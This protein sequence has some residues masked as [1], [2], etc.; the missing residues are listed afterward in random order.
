MQRTCIAGGTGRESQTLMRRD[1]IGCISQ[2]LYLP[3]NV[4]SHSRTMY[5]I[6]SLD[7]DFCIVSHE[8]EFMLTTQPILYVVI[9]LH[10]AS[11]L[12][13]VVLEKS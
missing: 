10:A 4:G 1:N 12:S 11:P 2:Q 13:S 6:A 3:C 8:P 5:H 7:S 9:S